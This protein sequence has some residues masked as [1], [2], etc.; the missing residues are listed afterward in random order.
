MCR[1]SRGRW[2]GAGSEGHSC[3]ASLSRARGA[4]ANEGI[5]LQARARAVAVPGKEVHCLP[6]CYFRIITAKSQPVQAGCVRGKAAGPAAD[7]RE[8]SISIIASATRP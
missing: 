3:T 4:I 5:G 1:A 2:R 6:C 7:N 8:G